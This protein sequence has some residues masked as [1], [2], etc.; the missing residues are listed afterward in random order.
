MKSDN[1]VRKACPMVTRSAEKGA[2]ILAFEHPFAGKQFVKGTIETGETP[3]AA[4]VRELHEESG[5][6]VRGDFNFL[7]SKRMRSMDQLWYFFSVSMDGLPE[8]W[9]HQTQDDYGHIFRF[10]WRP[11]TQGL[12]DDWHRVFHEAYSFVLPHL[13]Q[14]PSHQMGSDRL[15]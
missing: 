15:M 3:L 11:I 4:A 2:E 14:G 7:G 5:L 12:D 9:D 1:S 10:F 13:K 6:I 8:R